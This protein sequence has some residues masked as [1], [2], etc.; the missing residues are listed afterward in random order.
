MLLSE[1]VYVEFKISLEEQKNTV[2][3]SLTHSYL[4]TCNFLKNYLIIQFEYFLK[5]RKFVSS[6]G[7]TYIY[8]TYVCY[9]YVTY[10]YVYVYVLLYAY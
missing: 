9:V 6:L 1:C 4:L 5:S 8:P 7:I 3:T 10:M 2:G